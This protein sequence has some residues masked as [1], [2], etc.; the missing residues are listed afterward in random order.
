MYQAGRTTMV[1]DRGHGMDVFAKRHETVGQ[2]LCITVGVA[3][4][5][6]GQGEC[7]RRSTNQ[8]SIWG[9]GVAMQGFGLLAVPEFPE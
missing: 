6:L 2:V 8:G 9:T 4:N 7:R 1:G 3:T 5:E